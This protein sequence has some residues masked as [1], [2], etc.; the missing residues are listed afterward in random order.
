MAVWLYGCMAV[1]LYG[2][3]MDKSVKFGRFWEVLKFAWIMKPAACR[4]RS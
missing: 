1:W 3:P 4:D 2:C